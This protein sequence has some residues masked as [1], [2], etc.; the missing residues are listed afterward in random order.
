MKMRTILLYAALA[1]AAVYLSHPQL[2]STQPVS[3]SESTREPR[4]IHI[5]TPEIPASE[6]STPAASL[7]YPLTTPDSNL[8]ARAISR[9]DQALAST[10][11]AARDDALARLLPEFM[12][13][14]PAATARFAEL[15][16]D[17]VLR[18]QLLRRVSQLWAARDAENAV[19]WAE[20]LPDADERDAVL[21]DIG[22]QLAI[23]DPAQAVALRERHASAVEPDS[24]LENFTQQWGAKDFYAALDWA[25]AQPPGRQRDMLVERLA[26]IQS[27]TAPSDAARLVIENIPEGEA[28]TTAI[29]TVVHQ[30][31]TRDHAMAAEWVDR[32]PEV[33]WRQ[34]ALDELTAIVHADE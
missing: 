13:H 10:D 8:D 30:W 4:L 26:F 29:M 27:Q 24:A 1:S 2:R 20:S 14:D 31:A 5:A 15:Y 25:R 11:Q 22:A 17:P 21:I 7:V 3:T 6:K 33:A 9:L 34:R 28:Q 32:F 19:A 12:N 23:D 16:V 18:E